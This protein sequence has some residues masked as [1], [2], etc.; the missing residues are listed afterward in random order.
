LTG[1]IGW[2]AEIIQQK[3]V[4]AGKSKY[5]MHFDDVPFIVP[6]IKITSRLFSGW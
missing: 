6:K 3:M 2:H 1:K 4:L 5:Q